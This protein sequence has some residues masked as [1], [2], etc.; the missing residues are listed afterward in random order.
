MEEEKNKKEKFSGYFGSIIVHVALIIML[1][2]LSLNSMP[3]EE[4]GI[5][6]NFGD[7]PTG[8]GLSEPVRNEPTG[9]KDTQ[10]TE[11][12]SLPS[13]PQTSQPTP[14]K[15]EVMTQ[16][17][18]ESAKIDAEKK[19][20]EEQKKIEEERKKQEEQQRQKRIEEEKKRKE[21]EE[22]KRLI[23]EEKRKK[24]EQE[25]QAQQARNNVSGA[26]SK[27]DGT[28][29]SEGNTQ[30]KGNQGHL[31]GDPNST[32]RDGTGLGTSG[33]GYSLSGRS[34]VGTLPKPV[35]NC[36]EEGVIVVDVTVDKT[37]KVEAAKATPK[38]SRNFTPCL[39]KAAEEAAKKAK[40]NNAPEAAAFQTGTITYHFGFVNK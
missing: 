17:Y 25:R 38:G 39:I 30:G 32:N 28:G 22:K 8:F 13:T 29:N 20:K 14:A 7:S 19:R 31:T 40:F 15:E 35:E 16:N 9:I 12:T 33:S 18:E 6:V 37:G 1:L 3:K 2:F 10:Q 11:E 34:L 21:E 5:L 27:T 4:E 24:E 23:A 26:F 36:N